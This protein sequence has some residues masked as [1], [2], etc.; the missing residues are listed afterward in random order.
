MYVDVLAF[1]K[2]SSAWIT[3]MP[4][5][6]VNSTSTVI[7]VLFRD[8]RCRGAASV[9]SSLINNHQGKPFTSTQVN[10]ICKLFACCLKHNWITGRDIQGAS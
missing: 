1:Q 10:H 7:M 5:A 3:R 4:Y 9:E 8:L 6:H 2:S